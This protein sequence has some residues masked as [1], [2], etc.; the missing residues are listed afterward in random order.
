MGLSGGRDT[1]L[2]RV[3]RMILARDVGTLG[4]AVAGS[5]TL[6]REAEIG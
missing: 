5:S 6:S 1:G 3:L 2:E 4:P